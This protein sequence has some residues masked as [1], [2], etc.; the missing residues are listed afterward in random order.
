MGVTPTGANKGQTKVPEIRKRGEYM[1]QI[2]VGSV[3]S[4]TL[5]VFTADFG[6]LL[7][8][9]WKPL[10]LLLAFGFCLGFIQGLLGV[11]WLVP[12]VGPF[13]TLGTIA[14]FVLAIHRYRL[15]GWNDETKRV[16]LRIGARELRFFGFMLAVSLFT[17]LHNYERVFLYTI[18][19]EDSPLRDLYFATL[20]PSAVVEW[21]AALLLPAFALAL[22]AIAVDNPHPLSTAWN[23]ARGNYWR[24][25]CIL[26]AFALPSALV[27]RYLIPSA[28]TIWHNTLLLFVSC[29]TAGLAAIALCLV[30]Q[31][32]HASRTTAAH[33]KEIE[34]DD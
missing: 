34:H 26:V 5:D 30:F 20:I 14:L 29:V 21:V 24:L 22:P 18:T 16:R 11:V 25:L 13:V 1:M 15:L 10:V 27:V 33:M 19:R 3:L 23:L 9:A 32:R 2:Q 4:R 8:L 31:D 6:K 28:D 12:T 17:Q 7:L